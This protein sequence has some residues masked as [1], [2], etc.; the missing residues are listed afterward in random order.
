MNR[1][2]DNKNYLPKIKEDGQK[3]HYYHQDYNNIA[4]KYF[5]CTL[6]KK[7]PMWDGDSFCRHLLGNSH[8]QKVESLIEEDVARVARLRKA[9]EQ[10]YKQGEGL[11]DKKCGLCDVKVKDII[12]HRKSES[13][14]QLKQFIHPQIGRA[15]V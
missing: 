10:F 12:K 13:H 5:Q 4:G 9:V 15:H 6:C 1:S 11:G 14:K 3:P 2:I 8:N 7:D